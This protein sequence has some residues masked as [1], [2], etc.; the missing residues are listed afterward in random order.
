MEIIFLGTGG[1]L[2]TK[3]RGLPCIVIKRGSEVIMFDCGE[4][5][6]KQLLFSKIGI[7]KRMKIL[8]SHMHGDHVLG[9]PGLFQTMSLLGR[10][11]KLELYGPKGIID[12]I[13][14]IERSVKYGRTF[15][16][17]ILEI[18]EGEV[19][20]ESEY[21]IIAA[22][23]DHGILCFAYSLEEKD[24]PGRFKP[25]KAK[26]L[27][28]PKG[29]LWKK[30]QLGNNLKID[31][32]LIKSN[33]VLGPSRPGVKIVYATDTRPCDSIINL[34]KNSEILIHDSTFDDHNEEKAKEYGHSTATQ[35]A[36]VAKKAGAK[37]LVLF[38]I[39]AM[40]EDAKKLVLQASKFHKETMLAHDFKKL[41]V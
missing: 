36:K 17:E 37:K 21:R 2:P 6:Q 4:G 28:I 13:E 18:D 32:K 39:S 30:L 33:E 25:K 27:G 22:K 11:K 29:P 35:A 9:L 15:E 41:K 8:V 7:N 24:K 3:T 16:L 12:F 20:E 14:S 26:A 38:H 10:K 19:L 34:A 1:S 23:A 40:H 31:G 5:T